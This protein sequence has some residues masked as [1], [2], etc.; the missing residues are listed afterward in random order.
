MAE[1]ALATGYTLTP[2]REGS[3]TPGEYFPANTQNKKRTP[4]W[5]SFKI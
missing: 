1:T 3:G 4:G 2:S 5:M